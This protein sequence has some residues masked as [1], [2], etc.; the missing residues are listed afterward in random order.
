M[1][2]ARGA[3]LSADDAA[4]GSPSAGEQAQRPRRTALL[5]LVAAVAL[6]LDVVTKVLVVARLEG[7]EPVELLGGRLLLRVTR[8]PGAAFSFAEGATVLFTAVAAVVVVVILR[9]SRRL[10]SGA[11]ALSLGLLLGGATG[12]LVDRLLRS[13]GTGRGAVVDFI[14]FQVWPSFNVADSAI[15]LGGVL[16]VLLSLRGVELDGSRGGKPS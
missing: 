1:Q 2:A 12:N 3:P 10:H 6:A 15:V 5:L 13:P 4:S 11:W 7:G 8:N 9:V 14:D 16:A